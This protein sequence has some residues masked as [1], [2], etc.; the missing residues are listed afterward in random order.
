MNEKKVGNATKV[1]DDVRYDFVG[2]W[3]AHTQKKQRCKLC[4]KTYSRVKC[5]KCEKALCLTKDK[6]FFMEH[7]I[8]Q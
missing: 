6:N 2:H 1:V 4:I 8:K 7:H 5:V 3:P